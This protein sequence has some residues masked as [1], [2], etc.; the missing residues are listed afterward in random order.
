MLPE[1]LTVTI[2]VG[3]RFATADGETTSTLV[4]DL[5]EGLR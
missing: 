3:G 2:P 4:E 1:P 5:P